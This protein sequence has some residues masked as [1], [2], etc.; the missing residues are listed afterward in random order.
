MMGYWSRGVTISDMR[1]RPIK[2]WDDPAKRPPKSE[3]M[4]TPGDFRQF[5]ESMRTMLKAKPEKK[6][7][8]ASPG[9]AV[10]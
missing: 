6:P 3:T 5:T 8:S 2:R 1:T 4:N 9:V 7:L 10:S